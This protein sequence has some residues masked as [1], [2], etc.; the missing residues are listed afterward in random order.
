VATYQSQQVRITW[1]PLGLGIIQISDAKTEGD[2]VTASYV[3]P[4]R[5]KMSAFYGR[6]IKSTATNR[7]GTVSVTI[8]ASSRVNARL[9]QLLA[10]Q[11]AAAE[12]GGIIFEGPLTV[13]GPD[14]T[15]ELV[16]LQ[17]ASLMSAPEVTFGEVSP[18]RTWI[19]GGLLTM[20]AIGFPVE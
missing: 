10:T 2:F 6:L 17:G 7:A 9:Q 12:V 13:I 5:I 20:T 14:S 1:A 19:F 11:D 15:Q 16:T 18:N 8:P 4:E 3:D